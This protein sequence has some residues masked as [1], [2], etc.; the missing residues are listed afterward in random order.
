MDAEIL[1]LWPNLPVIHRFLLATGQ[2]LREI[3]DM[4]WAHLEPQT[5]VWIQV[6]T[7]AGVSHSI[8]IAE[9]VMSW[10]PERTDSPAVFI[11]DRGARLSPAAVSS[12]LMNH[13]SAIGIEDVTTHDLRVYALKQL[14]E[15]GSPGLAE[16]IAHYNCL[17]QQSGSCSDDRTSEK[18][19]LLEKWSQRLQEIVLEGGTTIGDTPLS[20]SH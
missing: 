18:A 10:L 8:T 4:D 15:L 2:G 3:V 9:W 17:G 1:A 12:Q 7:N 11:D 5:R 6:N 16:K 19:D 13:V 20:N 14:G